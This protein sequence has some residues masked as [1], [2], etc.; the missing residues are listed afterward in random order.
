MEERVRRDG[1]LGKIMAA[2]SFCN[3]Q[4]FLMEFHFYARTIELPGLVEHIVWIALT[5]LP[6]VMHVV[7]A[8]VARGTPRSHRLC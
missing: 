6:N 4:H 7:F 2:P 5:A 3:L 8:P 1:R